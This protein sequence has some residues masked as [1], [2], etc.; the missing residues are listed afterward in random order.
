MDRCTRPARG[1]VAQGIADLSVPVADIAYVPSQGCLDVPAELLDA[2]TPATYPEGAL[3]IGALDCVGLPPGPAVLHFVARV[4][5]LQGHGQ[6][7]PT[8]CGC[9]SPWIV[10]V[11][12]V[13][14]GQTIEL[15]AWQGQVPAD[16]SCRAG[17]EEV[18]DV[19][20]MVAADGQ[21][22][23]RLDLLQCDRSGATRCLFLTGT[24]F[25]MVLPDGG[26]HS[27]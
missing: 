25:G 2:G 6:F 20:V 17:P 23:A 19:A 12:L 13:V 11:G 14:D 27:R 22:H 9:S 4:R 5:L 3:G 21:F 18:R 26:A 16:N 7:T 24:Q 1:C 8:A 10:R 15:P